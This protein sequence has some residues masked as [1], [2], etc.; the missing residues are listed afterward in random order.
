MQEIFQ[1]PEQ[2]Y[3]CTY[4]MNIWMEKHD[5]RILNYKNIAQVA[6]YSLEVVF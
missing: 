4:R 3:V 1:F 2:Q 5:N 6:Y